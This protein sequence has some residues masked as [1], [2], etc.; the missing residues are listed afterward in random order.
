VLIKNLGMATVSITD[1]NTIFEE[2]NRKYFRTSY[3]LGM[4]ELHEATVLNQYCV[5]TKPGNN[6]IR[7]VYKRRSSSFVFILKIKI[8]DDCVKKASILNQMLEKSNLPETPN[9][10]P[11]EIVHRIADFLGSKPKSNYIPED[12]SPCYE[13][14]YKGPLPELMSDS[15]IIR[16]YEL[17]Y[18]DMAKDMVND[19]E[20]KFFVMSDEAFNS[21][22]NPILNSF[23]GDSIHGQRMARKHFIKE[24]F[25]PHYW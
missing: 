5:S 14:V 2:L 19:K 15:D 7:C 21:G 8:K 25:E 6:M 12:F 4:F 18:V 17:G 9:R 20:Q 11:E 13:R 23:Y 22:I 24:I 10:L 3:S 16:L 1:N